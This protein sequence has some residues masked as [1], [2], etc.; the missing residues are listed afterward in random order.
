MGSFVKVPPYISFARNILVIAGCLWI[1]KY[2]ENN[3]IPTQNLKKWTVYIF[4]GITFCVAGYTLAN[5]LVQKD[6]INVG[7]QIN[8]TI[9]KCFE[10]K[11][12]SDTCIVF[13]FRPECNHCWN[14]T[15]NVKSIKRT[16]GFN[17]VVGITYSD[18]DTTQYMKDMKPNFEILKYPNSDL[19]NYIVGVPILLMLKDGKVIKK[20]DSEDIP[21]GPILRKM[22][23]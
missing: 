14:T 6:K 2:F 11:I 18:V 22:L 12:S 15:E 23:E 3:E 1:W 7:E 8:N 19:Y 21:C 4:G 13:I 16:S 17:H 10:D 9:F 20:F 5:P